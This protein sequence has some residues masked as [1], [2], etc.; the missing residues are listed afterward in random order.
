[1][2]P[3]K[4]YHRKGEPGGPSC[5]VG[6]LPITIKNSH[7]EL[8]TAELLDAGPEAS[9]MELLRTIASRMG[10]RWGHDEFGW[11]AVVCG[12]DFPSW[13]VWRQDDSGV[14]YLIE[15]NLTEDRARALVADFESKGHKQVYWYSNERTT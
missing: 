15:A 8:V 13:A 11:W 6:I 12:H 1:M 9:E 2:N 3:A 14:K 7:G 10:V 5:P 4:T